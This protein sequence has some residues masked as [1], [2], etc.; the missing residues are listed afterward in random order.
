LQQ[1]PAQPRRRG[2]GERDTGH[3]SELRWALWRAGG[4]ELERPQ[5]LAECRGFPA[6]SGCIARL[7]KVA[8]CRV[9]DHPVNR[10]PELDRLTLG[11][12]APGAGL[13]CNGDRYRIAP[14]R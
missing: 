11:Q 3:S 14:D 1:F 8:I 2:L 5:A 6:A 10:V 12:P 7:V 9:P 4:I 13:F